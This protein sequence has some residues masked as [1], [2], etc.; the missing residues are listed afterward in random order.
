MKIKSLTPAQVHQIADAIP[1]TS[2]NSLRHVLSGRRGASAARAIAI[3]KAAAS[4]GIDLPRE[5]LNAG[6]AKCE[7]AKACRK[8]QRLACK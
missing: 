4:V 3:E 2:I 5:A 6:C 7:F 8:A 1:N